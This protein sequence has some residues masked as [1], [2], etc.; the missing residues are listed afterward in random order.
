MQNT[1]IFEQPLMEKYGV[2][3]ESSR[4]G[5]NGASVNELNLDLW[6][7]TPDS[8]TIIHPVIHYDYVS[9]ICI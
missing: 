4:R 2:V 1:D 8:P 7:L 6:F 3:T 5:Y 9:V